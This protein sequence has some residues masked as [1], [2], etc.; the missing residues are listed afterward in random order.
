MFF[1]NIFPLQD[2]VAGPLDARLDSIFAAA[3]AAT[4]P[5]D[6]IVALS[7]HFL[8]KPY[9]A[10][11]LIGGPDQAEQL[12]IDL[13]RFDCFTYLDTVE[14]LHRSRNPAQFPEQLVKV[15]YRNGVV[16]YRERRHFFSDWVSAGNGEVTDVTVQIGQDR[17]VTV[18]KFLN[19][20]S[21]GSPWLTGI[22]VTR[23]DIHYIPAAAI[24]RPVLASLQPG[25]Y[26]GIY[27]PLEGLDVSHTGLIVWQGERA[28][29]RHASSQPGVL[30]VID[31][32][33]LTYLQ[34]KPGLVVYR[35]VP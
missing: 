16:G 24:N 33:L 21:D 2:V 1:L 35:V 31:D 25:D 23:R 20:K 12:V 6:R 9:V 4:T 34:G 13:D 29:L 3:T 11:T 8:G 27:S 15:R 14:A 22:G 28:M 32:D 26:V 5:G 19:R 17:A 30:R 18:N 10:D 7:G